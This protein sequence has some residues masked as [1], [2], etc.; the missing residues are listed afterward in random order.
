[1]ATK[2]KKPAKVYISSVS[3]KRVSKKFA[4]ENPDTTYSTDAKSTKK[5]KSLPSDL[6]GK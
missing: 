2:K 6:L 1:M 4:D 3:G 5:K